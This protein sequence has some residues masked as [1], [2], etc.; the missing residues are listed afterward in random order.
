M[1]TVMGE[2]VQ[3]REQSRHAYA[4]FLSLP[5]T[6][7]CSYNWSG[8]RIVGIVIA[9]ICF[10][11]ACAILIYSCCLVRRRRR[12]YAAWHVSWTL[13]CCAMRPCWTGLQQAGSTELADINQAAGLTS[14]AL[15]SI[16]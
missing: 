15:R 4:H 2:H 7:C 3:D 11:I 5:H 13:I 1:T 16:L 9:A 10:A 14:K 12:A 6:C 8:G